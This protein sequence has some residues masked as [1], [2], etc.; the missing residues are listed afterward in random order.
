MSEIHCTF[1]VVSVV[2]SS[3]ANP[4]PTQVS[5]PGFAVDEIGRTSMQDEKTGEFRCAAPRPTLL[6]LL[7]TLISEPR[8]ELAPF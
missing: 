8:H 4:G 2:I 3:T 5:S 7:A 6:W 1:S